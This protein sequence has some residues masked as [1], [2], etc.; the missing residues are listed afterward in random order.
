M[1][2]GL[3]N[4]DLPD[5]PGLLEPSSVYATFPSPSIT[6]LEQYYLYEQ[7]STANVLKRSVGHSLRL[8]HPELGTVQGTLI[9]FIN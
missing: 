7:A 4:F 6:I 9:S 2:P 8:L 3:S 1:A 5:L